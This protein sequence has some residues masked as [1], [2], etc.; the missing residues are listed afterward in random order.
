MKLNNNNKSVCDSEE[1]KSVYA[2]HSFGCK[3]RKR[4]VR[5]RGQRPVCVL[6]SEA[7]LWHHDLMPLQ[8]LLLGWNPREQG[9]VL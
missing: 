5:N 4:I 7:L 8:F 6:R 3:G 9:G 2:T 1:N